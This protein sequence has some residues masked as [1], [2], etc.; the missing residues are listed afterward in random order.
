[1]KMKHFSSVEEAMKGT[2]TDRRQSSGSTMHVWHDY[3]QST[4][5]MTMS[6]PTFSG[7]AET[8]EVD[9]S[10]YTPVD[11]ERLHLDDPFL[12]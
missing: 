8:E 7:E 4:K 1:M 3:S 5:D 12:Y 2:F 6:I 11:L 10:K 9:I